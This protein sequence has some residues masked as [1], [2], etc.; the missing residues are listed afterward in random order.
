MQSDQQKSKTKSLPARLWQQLSS[1]KFAII[2]LVILAIVSVASL[3]I[4][5]FYPVTAGGPGWQEY[6]QQELG[7]S[8][9]LFKV[10]TFFQLHDP[11]RSWWYRLL[12]G[13]LSLSLFVC[14]ID[15]LP[16]IIKEIRRDKFKD[17]EALQR[18]KLYSSFSTDKSSEELIKRLPSLFRFRSEESE[19]GKRLYGQRGVISHLGQTFNHT[20][21]LCL[22]LGGLFTSWLGFSTSVSGL[23]GDIL[24]DPALDFTVRV[25]SFNI[26]YYPLGLGQYVLVDDA[27]IG[28]IIKRLDDERFLLE[29]MSESGELANLSVERE[30][31]RNQYNINMDSGNISDYIA[32]LT[33]IEDGEEIATRRVE[34]NHPMRYK[35]FRFYQTSF[36]SNNPLVNANID[37]ALVVIKRLDDEALVDTVALSM[38]GKYQLPDGSLLT[39]TRFL[40]DFRLIDGEAMS[41]SGHLLNPAVLLQVQKGNEDLYH[42]WSF[43]RSTFHHTDPEARYNFVLLEIFGFTSQV[44]YPTILEVKKTPGYFLVWLGFILSTIGLG[45][46]FYFT[47]QRLWLVIRQDKGQSEVL[48]G[49]I[50]RKNKALFAQKF[51]NWV[52]R[53]Q[54]G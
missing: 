26:E 29:T 19:N 6:W 13:F 32:V 20:G 11:Y 3:F 47:P 4:G 24:S 35:G 44:T 21:L 25:D 7:I 38:D 18:L 2:V 17:T 16:T 31:L 22:V 14:I 10:L 5:E 42:Q 37:S 27:F 33:I 28:R 50:S 48:M 23:P 53:L 52:K 54:E 39:L 45:L 43:L 51:D 49:G 34:V 12:L 8:K 15:K 41:A 9:P 46:S 40:P 1:M 30:R 36:D